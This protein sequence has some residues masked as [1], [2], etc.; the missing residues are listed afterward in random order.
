L[1]PTDISASGFTFV[2]KEFSCIDEA[3]VGTKDDIP[4]FT[5]ASFFRHV[6]KAVSTA[7]TVRALKPILGSPSSQTL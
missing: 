2:L 1:K 3:W 4:G 7:V 5:G 6:P